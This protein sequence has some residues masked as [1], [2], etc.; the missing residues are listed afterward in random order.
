MTVV[1]GVIPI[2]RPAIKVCLREAFGKVDS[3]AAL[4][5]TKTFLLQPVAIEPGEKLSN[6]RCER[7]VRPASRYR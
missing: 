1:A 4:H 6:T 7:C 3:F 5:D 2:R